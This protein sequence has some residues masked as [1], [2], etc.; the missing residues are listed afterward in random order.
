MRVPF[1]RAAAGV[2]LLAVPVV[3]AGCDRTQDPLTPTTPVAVE[4]SEPDFTGTLTINGGATRNF[5]VSNIGIITITIADL[6]PNRSDASLSIGVGLGIWNGTS[7]QL[8]GAPSLFNDN[9]GVGS[10]IAG[11]A[12]GAGEFCVRVYDVGQ[13]T[14]PVAFTVG[15]KHY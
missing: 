9:A 8:F 7:C 4:V 14:E 13:L 11:Y 2:L 12:N 15:I 1:L 6:Q 10:G 5:T 3:L